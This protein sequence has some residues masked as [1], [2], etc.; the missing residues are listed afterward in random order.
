MWT[1]AKVLSS[2]FF[3]AVKISHQHQH[4][5]L[6]QPVSTQNPQIV[7]MVTSVWLPWQ[8]GSRDISDPDSHPISDLDPGLSSQ[9]AGRSR[10]EVSGAY[11]LVQLINDVNILPSV[12]TS[13]VLHLEWIRYHHGTGTIVFMASSP[14]KLNCFNFSSTSFTKVGWFVHVIY[15]SSDWYCSSCRLIEK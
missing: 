12:S 2:Y 9:K 1:R 10:Y 5:I 7:S 15:S 11:C 3:I 6:Q 13:I 14:I 8:S 4:D